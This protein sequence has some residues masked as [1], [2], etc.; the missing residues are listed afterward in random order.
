[1]RFPALLAS[2]VLTGCVTTP[3]FDRLSGVTPKTV[4]DVIQCELATTKKSL[5]R[6]PN[7]IRLDEWTAVADLSLQVDEQATLTPSLSHTNLTSTLL[8]FDWGLKLD[9]QSTRI[10]SEKITFRIKDLD[11]SS[12]AALHRGIT[13]TGN[14]GLQ[15]V[16]E[17][18]FLSVDPNDVGT[19]G[20]FSGP[21]AKQGPKK[22]AAPPPLL[23]QRG[24]SSSKSAGRAY[25][26]ARAK[27]GGKTEGDF[28]T[29]IEFVITKGIGPAGPTWTLKHFKGPGNKLFTT[30]RSDTH[31]VTISFSKQ[32]QAGA[33]RQNQNLKM[34]SL[35]SNIRSLRLAP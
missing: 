7:P 4:V 10:Y 9:T 8:A 1:M 22:S 5:A 27:S 17:M 31:K 16:V 6:R 11:A 23:R 30:Q 13:L 3:S 35:N 29:S 20:P 14:L 21:A 12:C 26:R 33:E 34:E 2:L 32:G 28:G 19:S 15:E 25:A 18:A 24:F